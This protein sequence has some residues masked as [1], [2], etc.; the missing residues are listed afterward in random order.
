[1]SGPIKICQAFIDLSLYSHKALIAILIFAATAKI[2][3]YLTQY[4]HFT[5]YNTTDFYHQ[6]QHHCQHVH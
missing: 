1:M 3:N 6:P 4:K 5:V 2:I